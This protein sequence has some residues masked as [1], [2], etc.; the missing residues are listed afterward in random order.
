MGIFLC[1]EM[2]YS[3]FVRNRKAGGP[4]HMMFGLDRENSNLLCSNSK[5]SHRGHPKGTH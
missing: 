1:L 3:S 2:F 5:S 4:G